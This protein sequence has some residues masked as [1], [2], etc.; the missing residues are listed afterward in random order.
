MIKLISRAK[1]LLYGVTNIFEYIGRGILLFWVALMS[2][3]TFTRYALSKPLIFQSDL[4]SGMLV[5]FCTFCFAPVFIRG[6]H[7]RVDMITRR[8]PKKMQDWFWLFADV[9][10]IIYTIVIIVSVFDLIADSYALNSKFDVSQI[11]LLPFQLCI[12]IG[13]GL[14][15][16]VTFVDF[17]ERLYTM[18]TG[19]IINVEK[20]GAHKSGGFH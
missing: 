3:G 10:I 14:L 13:F 4:V 8:L 20:S 9:V 6:G 19:N 15:G 1:D 2:V 7:I 5:V 11:Q 12:P 16:L 18:I 17:F